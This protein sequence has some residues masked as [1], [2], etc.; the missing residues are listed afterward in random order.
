MKGSPDQPLILRW[1][2]H[3]LD[4]D[5]HSSVMGVLNVTPDSFSDGG[6]FFDWEK[7]VEHGLEMAA[8]GADII[9]VGG[10][11]TRPYAEEIP[12]QEEMDRVLPVVQALA[13][14]LKIPIS[15]DTVKAG[16]AREALQAGASMI[17]D[18]SALRLDPEMTT[19]AAKA[20]VPVVLMH[21]KGVPGDMQKNPVYD[22][23]M[24]E[25]TDF[26]KDALERAVG[27]WN[28][29]RNDHPG[30]RDR[31]RKDL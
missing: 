29:G 1:A 22:D 25:I 21:M 30:P 15:I 3:S 11:S 16:V 28:P 23:L 26:L 7:A 5:R 6:Q 20:G 24:G 13:R 18:V 8:D 17:N 4:L 12:L 27:R 2:G 19:L 14:E 9:D 10:E 31:V